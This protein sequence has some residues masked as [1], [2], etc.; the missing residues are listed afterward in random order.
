[1]GAYPGQYKG[2]DRTIDSETAGIWGVVLLTAAFWVILLRRYDKVHPEPM[3]AV[4]S[5]VI[6]G[7]VGSYYTAG[8]TNAVLEELTGFRFADPM[9]STA[10]AVKITFLMGLNEEF[11]KALFTLL[12]IKDAKVFDEPVDAAVYAVSTAI[13]FAA[14]ENADYA[15]RYGSAVLFE[16]SLAS[17]PLHISLASIW[18]LGIAKG[19]FAYG[20]Y[21]RNATPYILLAGILHAFYNYAVIFAPDP[22]YSYVFAG[23]II[24]MTVSF[25]FFILKRLEALST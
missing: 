16:R 24:L 9:L 20:G 10:S 8:Y 23:V 11:F 21:I 25:M 5:M 17:M 15:V 14:F 1:M 12:I 6:I 2:E 18:A 4:V 13:G 3:L 19:K 7:G 22:L